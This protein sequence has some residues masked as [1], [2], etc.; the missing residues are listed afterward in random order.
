MSRNG[1]PASFQRKASQRL[2]GDQVGEAGGVPITLGSEV[3][4]SIVSI[5]PRSL[6]AR[7]GTI[8]S[9]PATT[10]ESMQA[11]RMATITID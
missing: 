7:T 11:F 8:E 5:A 4:R 9:A 1:Q 6:W 10:I 2:S 3:T